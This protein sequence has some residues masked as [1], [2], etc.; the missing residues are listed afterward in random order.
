M[1]NIYSEPQDFGLSIVKSHDTVGGY[2]FNTV[3]VFRWDRWGLVKHFVAHDSGCSCPSP[4]ES[5]KLTDLIEV[6]SFADI[7]SFA[8]E[9]WS[10]LDDGGYSDDEPS[11]VERAVA[12][13]MDGLSLSLVRSKP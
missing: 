5:V 8:R 1:S 2:G 11:E 6:R 12:T 7:D 4:F 10:T 13:L 9:K 3:V